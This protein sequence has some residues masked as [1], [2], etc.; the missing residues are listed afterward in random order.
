M[1][2]A[3]ARILL[4]KKY[5]DKYRIAT[6]YIEK[7]LSWP[8]I[9][10]NDA[11][12]LHRFSVFL[13]SCSNAMQG[14]RY[15]DKFEHLDNIKKI[16]MKL[17]YN[18]RDRWRRVVY[19]IMEADFVDREARI[20]TSPI[21]GKIDSSDK[22]RY[23][24]GS[25]KPTLKPSPQG[26]R[27]SSLAT[28]VQSNDSEKQNDKNNCTYCNGANHSLENCYARRKKPYKERVDFLLKKILCFG[29]LRNGHIAKEYTNRHDCKVSSCNG[30][31]PTVLHT[32]SSKPNTAS[33]DSDVRNQPSPAADRPSPVADQPNFAA[34]QRSPATVH[35]AYIK[36]EGRTITGMAVIPVKVR[37]K[38]TDNCMVTY[39]FLDNGSTSSF[40]TESLMKQLGAPGTSLNDQL[41]KGPDLTNSLVGVLVRFRQ[42]HVALMAD[43]EAMF[44]QVRVPYKD[45]NVLRFYW[46][47]AGDI[48]QEPEEY[49]M[50][51]HLFGAVSSPSCASFA[52]RKTALDNKQD[53]NDSVV[54]TVLN[55]FYVDDCLKSLP[56]AQEAISHSRD[57]CQLLRK[58][59][60]RLTKWIS[61]N[62]EVLNTIPEAERNKNKS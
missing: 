51:V 41:F 36:T 55:N 31:H 9:R 37:V 58:G 48:E 1:R 61:N 33:Y 17:P 6:A 46:W 14:N 40:C 25:V 24:S 38:G 4:Q 16:I 50:V 45:C 39:A 44:H 12:A 11:Q 7:A 47:T 18:M 56:N 5:G 27:T 29:G 59:G 52:L 10:I 26:T 13:T 62:R 23:N 60:F 8:E 57:L 28:Q 53:Y 2:Y 34:D 49:Q 54:N 35:N 21:F 15:L 43:I 42:D 22:P 3:Q 20:A 19:D 30:K 32:N